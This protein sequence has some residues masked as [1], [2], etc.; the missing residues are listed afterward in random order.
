[1]AKSAEGANFARVIAV[2][3]MTLNPMRNMAS[4]TTLPFQTVSGSKTVLTVRMDES[5]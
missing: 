5:A 1:M 4:V 2:L 3:V